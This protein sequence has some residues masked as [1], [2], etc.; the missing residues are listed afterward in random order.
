MQF[1]KMVVRVGSLRKRSLNLK[2]IRRLAKEYRWGKANS[3][4]KNTPNGKALIK[5]QAG[6][7]KRKQED[8]S[9]WNGMSNKK[10]GQG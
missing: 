6:M 5:E 4:K 10:G 3:R 2:K 1:I 8:E 9:C 7:V